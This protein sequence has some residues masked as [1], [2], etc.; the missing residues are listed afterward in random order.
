MNYKIRNANAQQWYKTINT[1]I[2][3]KYCV[4]LMS[5]IC[6]PN[7]FLVTSLQFKLIRVLE[8]HHDKSVAFVMGHKTF[9]LDLRIERL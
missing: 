7:S 9:V 5:C 4:G 8:D 6:G 2:F 1:C 3:S